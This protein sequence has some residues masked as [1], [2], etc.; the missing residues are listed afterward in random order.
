MRKLVIILA[1]LVSSLM[2]AAYAQIQQAPL[3]QDPFAKGFSGT[4][5]ETTNVA[6]YTY[7]R[8]DTGKEKLWAAAPR[9]QVK[10][11]DKVTVPGGMAIKDF[12][13][14]TLNRTF[15]L[16]YF[17]G[18]ISTPSSG[19]AAQ[20]AAQDP[21]AGLKQNPPADP[22]AGLNMTQDPHAGLAKKS[23][24]VPS[25]PLTFTGITKPKG[26]LTVA[27]IFKRKTTLANQRVLVRG[28]VAKFNAEVMNKNWL[29]L[30]DGT[31]ARGANDLTVTTSDSA[32]PGDTVLVEGVLALNKD[33]GYGY[34][35]E[36]LLE[37]AKVTVEKKATP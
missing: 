24:S 29:H 28:K 22:H 30:Q 9:L 35:Y 15:D 21:H 10:V 1:F 27:E 16:I 14:R 4:V 8:V 32:A 19:P 23:A 6:N 26:G 12:Q 2:P 37:N 11:G 20:G 5:I 17:V 3:A 34:K 13:S 33:F 18:T 7:L 31:G 25:A 36:L